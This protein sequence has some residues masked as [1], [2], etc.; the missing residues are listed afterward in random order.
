MND[1]Y[2]EQL[3][4]M[5]WEMEEEELSEPPIDKKKLH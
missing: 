5:D 1:S 2:E 3:E 4:D